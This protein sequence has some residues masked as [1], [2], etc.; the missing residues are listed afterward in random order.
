M[1]DDANY[2]A[3]EYN[4]IYKLLETGMSEVKQD[5]LALRR[6][7]LKVFIDAKANAAKPNDAHADEL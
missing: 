5:E 3:N 4:R 6:N 7:V 2:P 1:K